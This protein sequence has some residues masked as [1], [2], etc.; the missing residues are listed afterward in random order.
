[1]GKL[2]A[3]KYFC[4]RDFTVLNF[5]HK[6]DGLET[7]SFHTA[8]MIIIFIALIQDNAVIRGQNKVGTWVNCPQNLV[9]AHKM[10]RPRAKMTL[11]NMFI[12]RNLKG[13]I[14]SLFDPCV[15]AMGWGGHIGHH[16][17]SY[18]TFRF[19]AIIRRDLYTLSLPRDS[20]CDYLYACVL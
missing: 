19:G 11:E 13:G 9:K 16:L 20:P 15:N 17:W 6:P 2:W 4:L 14:G 18:C 5:V 3:H 12:Q 7:I 8:I 10:L 1:M